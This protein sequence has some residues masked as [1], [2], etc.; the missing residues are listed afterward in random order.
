MKNN[1]YDTHRMKND[2]VTE[3]VYIHKTSVTCSEVTM[4][5]TTVQMIHNSYLKD[6]PLLSNDFPQETD[7]LMLQNTDE[8]RTNAIMTCHTR[9][10]ISQ[11]I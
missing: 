1:K 11:F 4:R 7:G 10:R 9:P 8:L 5:K 2:T 6:F 3:Y